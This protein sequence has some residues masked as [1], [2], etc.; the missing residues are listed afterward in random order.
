MSFQGIAQGP[1]YVDS[2]TMTGGMKAYLGLAYDLYLCAHNA[3][4]PPLL[5]KRLKNPK[6]FEGALYETFVIGTFA[7]AGFAIEME[8]EDNSD[9]AHGEFVAT[10]VETGRKFCVEAKAF[11][12]DSKRS[13]VTTEP[14]KVRDKL[15]AAL[16]KDLLYDRIIFIELNRVQSSVEGAQVP[17]WA[18]LIKAEMEDAEKTMT[19][20]GAPTPPAYVFVTNR[21]LMYMLD[22]TDFAE[23][24]FVRGFK[25]PEF[26]GGFSGTILDHVKARD[27]HIELHW[28]MK[29]MET[30]AH[31]P[32]TFDDR[33]PEQ[34]FSFPGVPGR[35][36][37]GNKYLVTNAE[38]K[39]VEGILAEACVQRTKKRPYAHSISRTEL[40]QWPS[41]SCPRRNWQSIT[42]PRTLILALLNQSG[43]RS[44]T[45]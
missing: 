26:G 31:I 6:T 29:A 27:R 39:L 3:Q 30:H 28:L 22:E 12:S 34:A 16:A 20:R 2:G 36:Q 13:G 40:Q 32:S 15:Y 21:P 25:I 37:I 11:T 17:D 38:G 23:Y 14:P 35:L 7:K 5:I 4:I 18:P 41:L 10:H 42:V 1:K 24:A 43:S 19:I 44:R 8:D 45:P 33:T 9:S